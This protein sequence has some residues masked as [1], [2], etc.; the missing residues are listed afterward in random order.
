L[1]CPRCGVRNV[2]DA[3]YCR[4]CGADISF[5]PQA[6]TR[7]LPE[8]ALDVKKIGEELDEARKKLKKK[9]KEPPTLDKGLAKCMEGVAFLLIVLA[10]FFYFWGGIMLW[11]WF[12]IPALSNFGEGVGQI[13]RSRREHDAFPTHTSYSADELPPPH[14]HAAGAL[15]QRETSEIAAP[16]L[17]VTEGTTR[18]LD[19]AGGPAKH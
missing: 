12:I 8:T 7:S 14:A 17:S 10:G 6:L 1:F 4:A 15:P 11:I 16:P 3:K 18:H 2:E 5:V 9:T 13:I 19:A